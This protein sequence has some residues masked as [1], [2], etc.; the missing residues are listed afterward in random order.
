L[1]SAFIKTYDPTDS[2]SSPPTVNRENLSHFVGHSI[3]WWGIKFSTKLGTCSR[4]SF[5]KSL[6]MV[7]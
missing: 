7:L 3:S 2:Q 4:V 5:D 6:H 1:L